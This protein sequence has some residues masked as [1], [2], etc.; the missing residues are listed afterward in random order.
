MDRIDAM[1]VFA[2]VVERG[3]FVRGAEDLRLPASTATDAVKQLEA[4]LGVRLLERT[5]RQVRATLDG[6]AYYRRCLSILDDIEEPKAPSMAPGRVAC[7]ALMSR[8]PR[9]GV[10][11][12]RRY[13]GFSPRRCQENRLL[14]RSRFGVGCWHGSNLLSRVSIST[15]RHPARRLV[16][17]S[18]H[19]ELSRC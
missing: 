15:G 18:F 12:C 19:P 13:A 16:V 10:S 11:S 2:R 17:P 9:R 6:E 4:R 1:R 14:G 8:A 7:C 5:T 3:S